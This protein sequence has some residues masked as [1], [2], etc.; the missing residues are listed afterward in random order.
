MFVF[1]GEKLLGPGVSRC[2][3]ANR[4]T[5]PLH[6]SLRSTY[7]CVSE[8]VPHPRIIALHAS[9][10]ERCGRR[11]FPDASANRGAELDDW[12]EVSQVVAQHIA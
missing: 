7:H 6:V 5:L 1:V 2:R 10:C 9:L 11:Q 12:E 4:R 8:A 3:P